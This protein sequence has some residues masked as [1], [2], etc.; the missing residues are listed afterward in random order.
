MLCPKF[1]STRG[2][3]SFGSYDLA[4]VFLYGLTENILVCVH[5]L[6]KKG[7]LKVS[8]CEQKKQLYTEIV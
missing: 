1:I 7:S 3:H 8:A 4:I 2:R 6:E 5:F